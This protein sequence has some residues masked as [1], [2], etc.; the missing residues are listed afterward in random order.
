[1][2]FGIVPLALGLA[3]AKVDKIEVDGKAE[4]AWRAVP[5]YARFLK[6]GTREE[7]PQRTE[8]RLAYSDRAIFLFVKCFDREVVAERRAHDGKVWEDDSVEFF[9]APSPNWYVQFIVNAEGSTYEGRG[10][11]ADWDCPWRA[12]VRRFE[13]GWQAELEIPFSSLP[14]DHTCLGEWRANVCRNDRPGRG[15]YTLAPLLG[16]S[17]H[18]PEAFLPLRNFSPRLDPVVKANLLRKAGELEAQIR[19]L[20]EG[21]RGSNLGGHG[22]ALLRRAQ[23]RAKRLDEAR[24]TIEAGGL[25]EGGKA[26]VELREGLTI[27]R[28]QFVRARTAAEADV[29]GPYF[30]AVESTLTKVRPDVPYEGRPARKA[31]ISLAKG[32]WEGVQFVIVPVSRALK[33]VRVEVSELRGPKG[34]KIFPRQMRIYRIGFVKVRKPTRGGMGVG[35]Y[36]DPLI[37]CEGP[38]D[39]PLEL[40]QP[41]WLSVYAPRNLPAGTY[42]GRIA[43]RPRN[44]EPYFLDIEAKVY[45][46]SLPQRPR[47]RTAFGIGEGYL[48]RYHGIGWQFGVWSGAD[49]RGIPDYFGEGVFELALDGEVRHSGKRSVRIDGLRIR[50]GKHEW[51]RAALFVEVPLEAG[52]RYRLSLWYRTTDLKPGGGNVRVYVL[53]GILWRDL[54]PSREW[55]HFAFEFVAKESRKVFVYLANWAV[56]SVWFDDVE[57]R[58]LPDGENLLPNPSFEKGL[59]AREIKRVYVLELLK[60]RISPTSPARPKVKVEG[61]KVEIDWD[62]FDRDMELF[63]KRGLNAFNVNWARLPGGWGR[64]RK[65]TP[66]QVEI[67]GRILQ[68]TERHLAEKGWLDMA[69]VYVIDEPSAGYFPQVKG[70]FSIVKRFAPKLK[71]LLTLGYG[72]TRPWRPGRSG[73]PAYAQLRDWVDIWVPHSDCFHEGFMEE[74]RR[75]GKEIW[76]YVC[77]SAQKPY[78]NIWAID[79]PGADHRILFWQ[80]WRYRITGFLYW[81]T[82]YWKVNPWEEAMTYP[83]GNGDGSLFY[84]GEAGPIGSIRLE[85]IRDGIEDYDYLALLSELV[86]EA[87]RKGM[88][89]PLVKRARRL[90]DVSDLAPSWTEYTE[91][92]ER[93]ERRRGEIARAI[94]ELAKALGR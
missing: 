61:G 79:Y 22:K 20:L 11:D 53:P 76:A 87:E 43:F 60:H 12:K 3:T 29:K 64:V 35:L 85:I 84:P 19:K 40:L 75:A 16:D 73:L 49:V 4:K 92:P 23:E 30:V 25:C 82:T 52:R 83:G 10:T 5:A 63:V 9:L 93:L 39:V 17:F 1:M 51:P 45:D 66:E 44:A 89:L 74:M 24:K 27:L 46:F 18:Q 55:K 78:A 31:S 48:R 58:P 90:L 37:P 65:A 68:L 6:L 41:V 7:A 2:T 14:L 36:P 81:S 77:I 88:K 21:L 57:L 91:E 94:E 13:G 47:L 54:P 26:L 50:R 33:D 80:L 38:F 32:E 72:A 71:T 69:Y 42:R 59:P 34:A 86:G 70:C 8:A 15:L 67:A 28:I 56:G 62:E